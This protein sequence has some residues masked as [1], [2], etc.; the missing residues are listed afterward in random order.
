MD[1]GRPFLDFILR[2][3]RFLLALLGHGGGPVAR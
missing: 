1:T 2:I 3:L